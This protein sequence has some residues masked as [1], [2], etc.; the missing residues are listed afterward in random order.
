MSLQAHLNQV[1]TRI[2]QEIKALGA[3]VTTVEAA[4]AADEGGGGGAARYGVPTF[5]ISNV[6]VWNFR[7]MSGGSVEAANGTALLTRVML[8]D[9]TSIKAIG[10]QVHTAGSA[11][12]V[13]RISLYAPDGAGGGPGTLIVDAGTIDATSGGWKEASFAAVT[14]PAGPVW[15]A[16]AAQGAPATL[17]RIAGG[18]APAH[19]RLTSP[20]DFVGPSGIAEGAGMTGPAAS[21]W[22]YTIT[23]PNGQSAPSVALRTA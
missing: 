12:A 6:L 19:L 10:T 8:A 3:R 17:P 14:A 9:D 15:V 4:V 7:D 21:T 2:G 16:L 5:G 22:A 1:V 20:A 11:G 18:D 23:V 13:I